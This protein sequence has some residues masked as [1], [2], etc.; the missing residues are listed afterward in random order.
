MEAGARHDRIEE[1]VKEAV[2]DFIVRE[3]NKTSLIT[4]TRVRLAESLKK[5]E[6]LVTVYP[7]EMEDDVLHFLKRRGSE[8]RDY[9]KKHVRT[10]VIPYLDFMIDTGEKKRQSIDEL[11]Q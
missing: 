10:R 7:E 1:Y 5:G 8:I 4:V 9:V 11:L 6:V 2:A 3:S